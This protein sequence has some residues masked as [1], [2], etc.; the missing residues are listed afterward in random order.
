MSSVVLIIRSNQSYTLRSDGYPWVL[1]TTCR[2][3]NEGA[4]YQLMR[5]PMSRFQSTIRSYYLTVLVKSINYAVI[6]V[7]YRIIVFE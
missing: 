6:K 5:A 7:T 1:S 3:S 4:T 2:F